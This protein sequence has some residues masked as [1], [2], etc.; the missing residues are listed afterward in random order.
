MLTSISGIGIVTASASAIGGEQGHVDHPGSLRRMSSYAGIVPGHEQ[1]GGPDKPGVSTRV[2]PRCNRRLKKHLVLAAFRMGNR[3]GPPEFVEAYGKL[4][5][6]GQHADF[7]MARRLLH[8]S[9]AMMRHRFLYL[10]PELRRNTCSQREQL[11]DYLQETWP[12]LVSKWRD[13]RALDQALASDAPLGIW[14][15]CIKELYGSELPLDSTP[16]HFI[17]QGNS[18]AANSTLL[19]QL[20]GKS[21]CRSSATLRPQTA[22]AKKMKITLQISG[23][24]QN[25]PR[26]SSTVRPGSSFKIRLSRLCNILLRKFS[27]GQ[28][29][30]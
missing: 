12:K 28:C 17:K 5:R 4:K 26:L 1:T 11:L 14:R 24:L 30:V 18:V 20:P 2:K 16:P 10:P 21:A 7:I 23:I 15:E 8:M 6:D 3:L 13:A 9:K 22:Q 27:A 25:R 19:A 29:Q